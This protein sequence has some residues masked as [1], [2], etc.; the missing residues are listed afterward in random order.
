M[1]SAQALDVCSQL[2]DNLDWPAAKAELGEAIEYLKSTG[3]T[4][5]GSPNLCDPFSNALGVLLPVSVLTGRCHGL[6]Y[7]R[8]PHFRGRGRRHRDRHCTL[9]R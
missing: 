9:L 4:K 7:G 5:V 8:C 1:P 3:A 6:L 2:M